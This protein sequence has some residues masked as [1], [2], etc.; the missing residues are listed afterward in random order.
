M[1]AP[2]WV[3]NL[4]RGSFILAPSLFCIFRA[5]HAHPKNYS[6]R[7]NMP[8]YINMY[9]SIYRLAA[10][11]INISMLQG[12]QMT[13][14][15]VSITFGVSRN[16]KYCSL[17]GRVRIDGHIEGPTPLTAEEQDSIKI[18]RLWA[19]HHYLGVSWCNDGRG[20]QRDKEKGPGWNWIEGYFKGTL[21][22]PSATAAST[23]QAGS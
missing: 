14:R 21:V 11:P 23:R 10:A 22:S 15:L 3:L 7:Y 5:V 16:N 12:G 2:V 1:F 13:Y 6:I 19:A 20:V 17:D 9:I 8:Y 4:F 18:S